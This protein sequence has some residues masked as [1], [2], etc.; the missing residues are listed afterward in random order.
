MKKDITAAQKPEML[1][2]D[3]YGT[4]VKEYSST[5]LSEYF[6]KLTGEIRCALTLL[7]QIE[8]LTDVVVILKTIL[9]H[10]EAEEDKIFTLIE[11]CFGE[12]ELDYI[13]LENKLLYENDLL[14]V[15]CVPP[16]ALGHESTTPA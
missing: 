6:Y 14:G 3:K 15:R 11:R 5:P 1:Y 9:N 7:D 4:V 8:D 2:K 12:L 10:V 13:D 16:E